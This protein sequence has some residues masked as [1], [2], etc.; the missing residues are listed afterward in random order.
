MVE[1]EL[2]EITSVDD[3]KRKLAQVQSGLFVLLFVDLFNRSTVNDVAKK[4]RG[5]WKDLS[6]AQKMKAKRDT[7][8]MA[9]LQQQELANQKRGEAIIEQDKLTEEAN[10]EKD[11]QLEIDKIALRDS[12]QQEKENHGIQGHTHNL[13]YWIFES[14]AFCPFHAERAGSTPVDHNK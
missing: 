5:H 12:N 7:E 13:E 2:S 1:C 3:R 14:M 6:E 4:L 9:M 10:R 8:A 11:R